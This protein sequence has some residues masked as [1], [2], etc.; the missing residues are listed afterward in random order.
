MTSK[1]PPT[2]APGPKLPVNPVSAPLWTRG[3][4]VFFGSMAAFVAA[5]AALLIYGVT[6]EPGLCIG[7]EPAP[8][9][10]RFDGVAYQPE[11]RWRC[12]EWGSS[13]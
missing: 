8:A 11:A 5:L 3:D 9:V 2:P 1:P 7:W 13:R 10:Y 6:R 12:V 4:K